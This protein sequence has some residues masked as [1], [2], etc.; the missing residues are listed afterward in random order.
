MFKKPPQ[1]GRGRSDRRSDTSAKVS[2]HNTYQG[3]T[4]T[5]GFVARLDRRLFEELEDELAS[6][7]TS[8]ELGM[9]IAESILHSKIS[10]KLTE[11]NE[12]AR[13]KIGRT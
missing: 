10:D 1:M 13:A 8:T 7:L 12:E 11:A 9:P 5:T 3:S 2:Y 4:P 6:P